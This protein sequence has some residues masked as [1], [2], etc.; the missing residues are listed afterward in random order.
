MI[1]LN[2]IFRYI[3]KFISN[4]KNRLIYLFT[5]ISVILGVTTYYV[6]VSKTNFNLVITLAVFDLVSIF[7]LAILITMK[8]FELKKN[9]TEQGLQ[10]EIVMIFSLITIIP[11]L[12]ISI[13]SIYFFIFGMQSWFNSKVTSM[14]DLSLNIGES[15]ITEHN[16]HLKNT[17]ISFVE[18]LRKYPNLKDDKDIIH[19]ILNTYAD[20]R[21]LDEV[22]LFEGKTR[23]ILAQ[24][25]YTYSLIFSSYPAEQILQSKNGKP[26]IVPSKKDRIRVLIKLDHLDDTYLIIGKIIDD[27]IVQYIDKSDGVAK[28]FY[29]LKNKITNIQ[30]KFIFIFIL[31]SLLLLLT[32]INIGIIFANK[33]LK[34]IEIL[35][36]AVKSVKQGDLSTRIKV[37]SEKNE[38]ALLSRGFNEM[39]TSIDQYRKDLVF[40]QKSLAWSDVARKV[41]H[42][43]KNPLTPI[44]LAAERLKTKFSNQIYTDKDKYERYIDTITRHI[45]DISK[46][47][48]DFVNFIRMP[49]PQFIDCNFIDLVAEL[50]A[51]RKALHEEISY[52]L[53]SN[54]DNITLRCDKNQIN[55][56][57]V[58]LFQNSEE[59]LEGIDDK[60]I[61]VTINKSEK[62]IEVIISDN[63]IGF[64]NTILNKAIEPYTTTKHNGTGLG[65]AIT[66]RIIKDHYGTTTLFNNKSGGASI[67]LKF[68]ILD[69]K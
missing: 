13:F 9:S 49:K 33:I 27:K 22:I 68:T 29:D 1:Q 45:D 11:T 42:E 48:F 10:T 62:E 57:F 52:K 56:V 14:L 41:A 55:Q 8:I 23:T 18:D 61:I 3:D 34:P 21:G 30:I 20:L 38:I 37:N 63:G 64:N 35:V 36:K 25:K 28:D 40:L 6:F 7:M 39:V 66:E 15:Y 51:G 31:I 67:C 24:S 54:Q 16:S 44:Q 60:Q 53:V 17:A 2:N 26:I 4:N 47:I 59:A 5:F 43:I 50:V 32:S 19:K 65:L 46:I 12:M 58:N 69:K